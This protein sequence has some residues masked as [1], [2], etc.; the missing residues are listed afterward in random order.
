MWIGD[1]KTGAVWAPTRRHVGRVTHHNCSADPPATES[2]L[3]Y[4]G[5]SPEVLHLGEIQ[6]K[7]GMYAIHRKQRPEIAS[8]RDGNP[9]A[10][11]THPRRKGRPP[12]QGGHGTPHPQSV[13]QQARPHRPR[14]SALCRPCKRT[15]HPDHQR[16]DPHLA[17]SLGLCFQRPRYLVR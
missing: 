4:Y 10:L 2:F 11:S 3:T 13:K 5:D 15:W 6:Y 17:E 12:A 1:V 7:R 9:Q 16:G 14:S 8:F